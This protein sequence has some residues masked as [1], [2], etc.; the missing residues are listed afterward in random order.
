MAKT[1]PKKRS[2]HW[3][4][5]PVRLISL[6]YVKNRAKGG[7]LHAGT[8]S[9]PVSA[10][11][12][13]TAEPLAR[14]EHPARVVWHLAWPVVALNSL[15]VLN[16]LLDRGFI[17]HIESAAVTAYGGATNVLFLMFSLA[18]CVA[19]AATALVS[20]AFGAKDQ[21]EYQTATRQVLGFALVAGFIVAGFCVA[22]SGFAANA[23]MPAD[24]PRAI[25]LLTQ[26]LVVY[27]AF[28]P[29]MYVIQAVAG[30]LR[31][32]GD[33]R[34]PMVISSIQICFHACL[35]FLLVFPARASHGIVIPGAGLGLNGGVVALT[36][37]GWIS[38]VIYVIYAGRTALGPIWK[39]RLPVRHWVHRI[40]RIATPAATQAVLRVLSLTVFTII[41]KW[42]P[43][44]SAAI[45]G[46]GIGFAIESIM[47][48]PGLGLAAAASALV[49]QS[50]GMRD[51]DRAERLGWTAANHAV[52]VT[53]ML[54]APIYFLAPHI[55][56][57]MV[58]DKPDI[59][60]EASNLIRY[61][62]VTEFFFSYAMVLMG[63]MQ[64]AG[65][66]MRPMWISVI[67]MW[68]LRVPIAYVLALGIHRGSQGA[69][70]AMSSTQAIQGMM[71]LWVFKQARWKTV[72]V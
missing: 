67:A 28:I 70:L 30:S 40:V 9:I 32:I 13:P 43:T 17:G 53:I 39:I 23:L 3:D 69:W 42:T 44:A 12:T 16:N 22:I 58:P 21:A 60:L 62:A 65:D 19:T 24:N 2:S 54:A 66:T 25:A 45:A 29:A 37:S 15:Q 50:L 48:M 46:M 38:A 34:S 68:F 31:A 20:R 10:A 6:I 61:L 36:V 33:T 7:G 4:A 51:P 11:S 63:A 8:I 55:A 1:P 72:R 41:L 56:Q 49:G 52:M 18:M 27:S 59:A 26:Y 35:N 5:F 14:A 57:I 47:F 71:A 64:G